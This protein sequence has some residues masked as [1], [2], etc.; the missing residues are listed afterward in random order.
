MYYV[1]QGYAIR[2]EVFEDI[3][4]GLGVPEPPVDAFATEANHLCPLWWGPGGEH[5]DAFAQS[6]KGKFLWMNPP[7]SMLDKVVH[8]L[9]EDGASAI[10]V[11]PNWPHRLWWRHLQ[12]MVSTSLFFP[13]G[14]RLFELSGRTCGPSRWGTWAYF[15]TGTSTV[16]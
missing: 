10:L 7:Y 3:L 13:R 6:W 1:R 11:V 15:I 8:K 5:E 2:R 12:V 9:A 4:V 16:A 14:H